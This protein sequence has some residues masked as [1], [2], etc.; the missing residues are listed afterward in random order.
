MEQRLMIFPFSYGATSN[1]KTFSTISSE[2]SPPPPPTL[3]PCIIA[4][5]ELDGINT[6]N[7][8]VTASPN[9]LESGGTNA[10]ASS[11]SSASAASGS[12]SS[13]SASASRSG[14]VSGGSSTSRAT[15]M[16]TGASG[17]ALAGG[18]SASAS[19]ATGGGVQAISGNGVWGLVL[20]GA[21]MMLGGVAIL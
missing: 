3:F 6:A 4:K 19:A 18:A 9:L 7:Y 12:G 8:Q 17:A 1:C 20:L 10:P 16:S 21:G 13:A 5:P 11:T 2:S 15:S 14:S